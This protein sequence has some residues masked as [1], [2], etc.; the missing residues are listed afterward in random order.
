MR[1]VGAARILADCP[2]TRPVPSDTYMQVGFGGGSDHQS[3]RGTQDPA[4]RVRVME[5]RSG[6]EPLYEVLQTSA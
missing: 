1:A 3:R 2:L 4:R 6:L 5:A